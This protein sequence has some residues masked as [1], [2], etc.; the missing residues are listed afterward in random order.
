MLNTLI[1][2][3][4]SRLKSYHYLVDKI[5]RELDEAKDPQFIQFCD[6]ESK[7]LRDLIQLN[8]QILADLNILRSAQEKNPPL[9]LQNKKPEE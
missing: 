2:A 4:E 6:C 8:K 5:E 7:R 9:L 3:Y 1:D